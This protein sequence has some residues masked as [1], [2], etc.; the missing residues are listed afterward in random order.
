MFSGFISTHA[1]EQEVF[2]TC[3]RCSSFL[4]FLGQIFRVQFTMLNIALKKSHPLLYYRYF[5]VISISFVFMRLFIFA[6]RKS[7]NVVQTVDYMVKKY[8]Q[9]VNIITFVDIARHY[10][11]LNCLYDNRMC[12]AKN[13]L[14][15]YIAY[16]SHYTDTSIFWM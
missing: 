3:N 16:R 13:Q 5:L 7:L 9:I 2:A 15:V 14:F 4:I 1:L 8:K 12:T 6:N 10:D 11:S